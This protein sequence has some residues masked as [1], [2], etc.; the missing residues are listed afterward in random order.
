[1]E[2][3][4]ALLVERRYTSCKRNGSAKSINDRILLS[5]EWFVKWFECVQYVLNRS[6]SYHCV[7]V[8][9]FG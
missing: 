1:M 4:N 6:V 5:K 2:V 8:L 3:V 7:L 9:K